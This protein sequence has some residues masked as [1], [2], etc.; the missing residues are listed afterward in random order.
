MSLGWCAL[1]YHLLAGLDILGPLV[2]VLVN[3]DLLGRV[4]LASAGPQ[5]L[6]LPG[7]PRILALEARDPRLHLFGC[8]AVLQRREGR[9]EGP[10]LVLLQCQLLLGRLELRNKGI[11]LL[12]RRR[13]PGLLGNHVHRLLPIDLGNNVL[14]VGEALQHLG[15]GRLAHGTVQVVEDVD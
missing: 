14:L 8:Q 10:G 11:Q 6:Q 4:D 2:V 9:L 7:R 13:G 3:L 5:L 1:L 12:G 15:E